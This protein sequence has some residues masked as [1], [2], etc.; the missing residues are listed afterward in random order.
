VDFLSLQTDVR[1]T[2]HNAAAAVVNNATYKL[3]LKT[4]FIGKDFLIG[5]IKDT[6]K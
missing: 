6:Q 5:F 1:S 2:A 3:S 4:Q